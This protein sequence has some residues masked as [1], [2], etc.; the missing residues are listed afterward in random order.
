MIQD[1]EAVACLGF[2]LIDAETPPLRS[3][4]GFSHR[5]Q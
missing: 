3:V 5:E 2:S 4:E 1:L